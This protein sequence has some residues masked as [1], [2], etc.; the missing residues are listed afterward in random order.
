MDKTTEQHFA[1]GEN[2]RRFLNHLDEERIR[3]AETS[4]Q[5]LLGLSSLAGKVFFDLGCGSGLFSLAARRLGAEVLSLDRD[6]QSVSCAQYLRQRYF[7][8]DPHWTI[9]TASILDKEVMAALGQ[10]EVVYSWGVLHHTGALWQALGNVLPLVAPGGKLA[11]AIYNQQGFATSVWTRVKKLY[12]SSHTVLRP[13]IAGM[14]CAYFETWNMLDRLVHLK[15]PLP[16]QDWRHYKRERG[17]SRWHDYVDW[18]GGYPF[19]AARVDEVFSFVSAAGM[20][21]EQ[22]RTVGCGLGCNE[23]VFVRPG[24]AP[25]GSLPVDKP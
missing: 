13:V 23:Y 2:W 10:A 6:A 5:D 19:E 18:A 9:R 24:Q 15:N 8:D 25:Q 21:L 17:M 12:V 20:V 1:F 16:F 3:A 7:P 11:I 14:V 22:L 4:L